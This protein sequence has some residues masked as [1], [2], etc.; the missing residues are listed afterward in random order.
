MDRYIVKKIKEFNINNDFN[1]CVL[2]HEYHIF[3]YDNKEYVDVYV[4]LMKEVSD[5]KINGIVP[6][7]VNKIDNNILCLT[8]LSHDVLFNLAVTEYKLND[9][10][11]TINNNKI[12]D[13]NDY[14][15]N[16]NDINL[17]EKLS[18]KGFKEL[19]VVPCVKDNYWVCS[20]GCVNDSLNCN[21]CGVLKDFIMYYDTSEK[22]HKTY[23]KR[24]FLN[25]E[26]SSENK[27]EE[28]NKFK[29]ELIQEGLV[30]M[31]YLTNDFWD[32]LSDDSKIKQEN[33]KVKNAN[34]KQT[35][36]NINIIII[37]LVILVV[38]VSMIVNSSN[39]EKTKEMISKYC[40]DTNYKKYDRV[41]DV[42]DNY[43]CGNL[44][45]FLNNND[46]YGSDISFLVSSNNSE[47]YKLYYDVKKEQLHESIDIV[48][49]Y[50]KEYVKYL[51]VNGYSSTEE[52]VST[53]LTN[54][55]MDDDLE[56]FSEF[57]K[58]LKGTD[59]EWE[60]DWKFLNSGIDKSTYDDEDSVYDKKIA[61]ENYEYSMA[62]HKSGGVKKCYLADFGNKDNLLF[63]SKIEGHRCE[64]KFDDY[65]ND[66][67]S[68]FITLY[69]EAF[70]ELSFNDYYGTYLHSLSMAS[71]SL[72]E[73]E[74][75]IKT[76]KKYGLDINTQM[77]EDSKTPGYTPLD[78]FI[79][80]SGCGSNV[81]ASNAKKCVEDKKYYKI[82]K[83]QGA[84]CNKRCNWEGYLK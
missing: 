37:I 10:I 29:L 76:F 64:Y 16:M 67:D 8:Y 47:I 42:L 11:I 72:E 26:Y 28:I 27:D 53:A 31:E 43:S 81:S 54:A 68:S 22:I 55:I 38:I 74:E 13:C 73:Y 34:N 79:E 57:A 7:S 14:I 84:K 32:S 23:A 39:D 78:S 51:A 77:T 44:V 41:S 3:I 70:K 33:F 25:K 36:R 49:D 69:Y 48:L 19:T 80:R 35:I 82:W 45:W 20:C 71:N 9:N 62:L 4:Y 75:K 52:M 83:R 15:L 21:I 66:T 1:S 60:D 56:L 46:V 40:D 6:L 2:I 58:L 63:L 18:L 65:F 17:L 30:N 50:N 59:Y 12:I 24:M 5:V 61:L